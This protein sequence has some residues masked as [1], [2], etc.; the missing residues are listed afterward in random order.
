M[1][2][3]RTGPFCSILPT[4]QHRG[5]PSLRPRRVFVLSQTCSPMKKTYLAPRLSTHGSVEQITAVF[6][7]VATRDVLR[8]ANGDVVQSGNLSI[9]ACAEASGRCIDLTP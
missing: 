9:N 3:W 2:R 8:N 4:R 1:R 5:A 7:N 6:G